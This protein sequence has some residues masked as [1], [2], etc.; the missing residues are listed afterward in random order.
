MTVMWRGD[1][2][3]LHLTTL[4]RREFIYQ[5]LNLYPVIWELSF[6]LQVLIRKIMWKFSFPTDWISER[7]NKT[8]MLNRVF[9]T[10]SNKW[11]L[12]NCQIKLI[13]VATLCSSNFISLERFGKNGNKNNNVRIMQ[14][15]GLSCI[16][17]VAWIQFDDLKRPKKWWRRQAKSMFS[18]LQHLKPIALT[19]HHLFK[20]WKN[21]TNNNKE[22]WSI[23]G[24]LLQ[25]L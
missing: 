5:L 3:T 8:E 2:Y 22:L 23:K 13:Q 10:F 14:M 20:F 7:T 12:W 15:L 6:V 21:W 11:I 17:I 16:M 18:L 9:F 4:N 19:Q 24:H 25:K 1:Y